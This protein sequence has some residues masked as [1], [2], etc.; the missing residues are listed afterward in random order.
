MASVPSGV[1]DSV[2]VIGG[3]LAGV[4]LALA[5]RE[6]GVPVRLIDADGPSPSNRSYGVI[7]GWPLEPSPLGRRAA[8]AGR[9]WQELQRKQ[10]DLGWGRRRRWPWPISQV[11]SARWAVRR[12]PVLAAA[13]VEWHSSRVLALEPQSVGWRLPL[14]D[15][16]AVVVGQVVLAAGAGCRT[17][18]PDLP[19]VLG[20][21]WAGVLELPPPPSGGAYPLRLPTRF[22]RIALEARSAELKRPEWVVDAGLVPWGG[23]GLLGQLSWV[24]PG[25][26]AGEA[27][28]P[29]LAEG[30]LRQALAAA[31]PG[32]LAAL[33]GGAGSYRQLP[34]AF[35]RDGPPLAGPLEV[36][37][38][39][40]FSGFRGAFAQVPVL[41]PL[42]AAAIAGGARDSAEARSELGRLGVLPALRG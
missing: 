28:D 23:G 18:H 8:G 24:A 37:G 5:L 3:G 32:P 41:A 9:R 15:G 26:A 39:W 11:D 35:C 13:G 12:G 20:V 4:L 6:H 42:L 19:A 36:P 21:S 1:S 40:L 34:V 33:A 2:G 16:G 38:Q 14:D 25:T 27:P 31:A 22:Q 10:G 29:A 7:P 17:L 30:W